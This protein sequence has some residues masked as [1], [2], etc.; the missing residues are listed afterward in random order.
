MKERN[1]VILKWSIPTRKCTVLI[2]SYTAQ[3]KIKELVH[4]TI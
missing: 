2:T 1:K 4:V 3:F